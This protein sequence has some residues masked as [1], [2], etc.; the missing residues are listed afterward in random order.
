MRLNLWKPWKPSDQ[1]FTAVLERRLGHGHR[2]TPWGTTSDLILELQNCVFITKS[3]TFTTEPMR[4]I[5]HSCDVEKWCK[6]GQIIV[7]LR[8]EKSLKSSPLV[9]VPNY[10]V[11]T[12]DLTL[13]QF[14]PWS[15]FCDCVMLCVRV[16]KASRI[17]RGI[18][19]TFKRSFKIADREGK[20][21]ES[22]F[23]IAQISPNGI[24]C[25]FWWIRRPGPKK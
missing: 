23:F 20:S 17:L 4:E 19:L 25:F 14:Y 5:N 18:E 2:T 13:L 12:L 24:D 15:L 16:V 21:R 10:Q 6:R 7:F 1:H 11:R 22:G 3:R 9:S 8:K